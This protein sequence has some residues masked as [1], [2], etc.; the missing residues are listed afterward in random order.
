ML[1]VLVR[2]R[3]FSFSSLF[4]CFAALPGLPGGLACC[5]SALLSALLSAAVGGSWGGGFGAEEV[6]WGLV[7]LCFA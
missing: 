1:H 7:F 2:F 4:L 6:D 3:F 5:S